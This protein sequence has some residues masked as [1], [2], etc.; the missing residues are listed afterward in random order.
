MN[1]IKV[2]IVTEIPRN[3]D[4]SVASPCQRLCKL[5]ENKMCVACLRSIDE[6]MA[7]SKSDDAY[8]LSV[9]R[10][11]ASLEQLAQS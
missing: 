4:G 3:E 8:K 7:W 2:E 9:W 11:L 1:E 5:D 10:R 6:I